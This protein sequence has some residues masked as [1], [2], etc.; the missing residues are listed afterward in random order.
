MNGRIYMIDG[1]CISR[2]CKN[3]GLLSSNIT[4]KKKLGHSFLFIK[5]FI[6]FG[7]SFKYNIV[8]FT[9][10]RKKINV[11]RLSFVRL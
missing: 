7:S 4:L 10:K 6:Y 5:F 8:S 1:L 9:F 11:A 2:K 3:A